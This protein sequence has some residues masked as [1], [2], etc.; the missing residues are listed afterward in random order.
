MEPQEAGGYLEIVVLLQFGTIVGRIEWI[1]DDHLGTANFGP[2]K[3]ATISFGVL[4][5]WQTS[6]ADQMATRFD[7]YIFV[8]FG[9]DLA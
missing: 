8:A 4:P 6:G 7:S 1:H 3:R 5:K 9:A 2:T